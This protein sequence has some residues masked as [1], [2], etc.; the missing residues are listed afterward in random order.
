MKVH[1]IEVK[2]TEGEPSTSLNTVF[3]LDGMELV[4]LNSFK[5]EISTG[6]NH[7]FGIVTMSMIC[8]MD[9]ATLAKIN[10]VEL[11]FKDSE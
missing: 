6:P 9:M 2:N 1:N 11:R 10:N 3:K 5:Y 4:G 8:Q 7:Y